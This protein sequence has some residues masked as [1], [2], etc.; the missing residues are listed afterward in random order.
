[1][2]GKILRLVL[3]QLQF[4]KKELLVAM[5]AIDQL[6]NANQV[7]LQLLAITPA[8]V[9]IFSLQVIARGVI[10]AV[11]SISR[12]KA[13]QS[14]S[15]I[16][17]DLKNSLRELERLLA[18]SSSFEK[19]ATVTVNV[20]SANSL[21]PAETGQLLS[22]LYRIQL[23]LVLHSSNF[24]YGSLKQ[25]QVIPIQLFLLLLTLI[26]VVGGFTR[27]I[28]GT[29]YREATVV[30]LGKDSSAI[31]LSTTKSRIIWND[32]MRLFIF[33]GDASILK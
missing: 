28:D 25:L 15:V 18:V 4:V 10:A 19:E 16:H 17:Q 6:F 2:S 33:C 14:T 32:M 1:M 27:L 8:I 31:F 23:L 12:G 24:E 5:E 13:L 9:A 26:P 20:T 3:I 30:D 21:S 22:H 29:Y 11:K 7:N